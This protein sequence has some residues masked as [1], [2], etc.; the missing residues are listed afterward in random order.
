MKTFD[1]KWQSH[2][3]EEALSGSGPDRKNALHMTG[4][5]PRFLLCSSTVVAWLPDVTEGHLTP[6]GVRMRNWKLYNPRISS[7]QCLL[8]CSLRRP[9]P[10][11][12]MVTGTSYPRP[13][14]SMVTGTSP[15]YLP[16]LFSYCF[17][18]GCLTLLL[19]QKCIWK[20]PSPKIYLF[21][22]LHFYEDIFQLNYTR[23]EI[24]VL[25]HVYI[26]ELLI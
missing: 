3:T 23:F 7:K 10:I 11:F 14:F 2:V 1:Q 21:L 5:F 9:R 25:W 20:F 17:Y 4:F 6:L 16:L 12:S 15:N 19:C 24:L 18:I 26:N 8:G 13:I 22:F